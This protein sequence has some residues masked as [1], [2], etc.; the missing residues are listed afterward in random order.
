M[1]RN[2]RRDSNEIASGKP[3]AV[4]ANIAGRITKFGVSS[5]GS[6]MKDE[7]GHPALMDCRSWGGRLSPYHSF[8]ATKAAQKSLVGSEL[9]VLQK[10][11]AAG[12][13]QILRAVGAT[14]E[15]QCWEP[16][17]RAPN[18]QAILAAG[19][20]LL[21]RDCRFLVLGREIRHCAFW[22]FCNTVCQSRKSESDPRARL[23]PLMPAPPEH[24]A[25]RECRYRNQRDN[26]S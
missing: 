2:W 14:I 22:D 6:T 23:A 4:Q 20:A 25:D 11:F 16:H 8:P 7:V 10:P 18:S 1:S 19:W 13:S 17:H 24:N 5:A 26:Q 12:I 15:K 21:I 9:I 3:G